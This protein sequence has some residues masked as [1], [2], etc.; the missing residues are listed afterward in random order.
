MQITLKDIDMVV[1]WESLACR[2]PSR[3]QDGRGDFSACE[4]DSPGVFGGVAGDLSMVRA[5]LTVSTMANSSHQ[6]A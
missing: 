2:T 5:I 3:R 1:E 6:H 4:G